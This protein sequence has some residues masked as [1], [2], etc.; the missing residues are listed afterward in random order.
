MDIPTG[1][2]AALCRDP[3]I[4]QA[5]LEEMQETAKQLHLNKFELP[6]KIHLVPEPWVSK[7]IFFRVTVNVLLWTLFT[8]Y[9][10]LILVTN[11]WSC[12][13]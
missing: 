7:N 12:N 1:N 6:R 3:R 13:W 11:K 2:F 8:N 9:C 5:V 10:L 4:I